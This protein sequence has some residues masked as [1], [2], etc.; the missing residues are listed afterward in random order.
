M[1]DQ[2]KTSSDDAKKK[3]RK[4]RGWS[5]SVRGGYQPTTGEAGGPPTGGSGASK[6][7]GA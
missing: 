1:A 7:P 5:P 4:M 6:K 3:P 2:D